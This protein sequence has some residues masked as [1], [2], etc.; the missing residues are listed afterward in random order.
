M[1]HN[2][3]VIFDTVVCYVYHNC[4]AAIY[5]TWPGKTDHASTL[6]YFEKYVYM[7]I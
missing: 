3:R 4:C 6:A 5:V 1:T 2:F 7:N